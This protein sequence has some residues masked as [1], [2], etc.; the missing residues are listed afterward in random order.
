MSGY[1]D[2]LISGANTG[3]SI[4][5]GA[6]SGSPLGQARAGLTAA[7]AYGKLAGASGW[8]TGATG[9]LDAL[10]IYQGLKQ[11]GVQGYGKAAGSGLQL[12]GML[13]SNPALSAAGGYIL[14][15]LSIYNAVNNWQSGK[16]G[17]NALNGAEAGAAVGSVIPG[18]GTLIGG[19][20][21]G[22]VGA[23]SSAFGP[24]AKDPETASVQGLLD[25]TGSHGNDPR[26]AQQAS[27]PYLELAGLMDRR[28][29]TLP[30]YQQYGRM[31]EQKFSNDLAG[32][33]NSAFGDQ[34]IQSGSLKGDKWS[35]DPSTGNY[36]LTTP[37]GGKAIYKPQDA[38]AEVYN[39]TIDPWVSSMGKGYSN[40][41]D[42]Y[43]AT[44]QGLLQDMTGQYL[45]GQAAQ[46]W[47]AVGGDSPFQNIYAGSPFTAAPAAPT[48]R[49]APMA[50]GERQGA[51]MVSRGG[52]IK[53]RYDDGGDVSVDDAGAASPDWEPEL[54]D[55]SDAQ[56]QSALDQANF[57][58]DYN[59]YNI[60]NSSNDPYAYGGGGGSSNPY[61][62]LGNLLQGLGL[63]GSS[64]NSA[65]PYAALLPLLQSVLGGNKGAQAPGVPS[66]YSGP[67]LNMQSAPAFNRQQNPIRMTQDQWLHSAEGP[68]QNFYSGNQLPIT[69]MSAPN[70]AQMTPGSQGGSPY[71]GA[72]TNPYNVVGG[73]GAQV[74]QAQQAPPS[75]APGMALQVDPGSTYKAPDVSP[76]PIMWGGG[77]TGHL[78]MAAGG[79]ACFGGGGPYSIDSSGSGLGGLGHVKGPG[80]G[81]SDS[82]ALKNAYLSNGEYVIDAPTVSMAGNGS[83][84]AG[85]KV[86]DRIRSDIRKH[87]GKALARGKQPM[88]AKQ[89]NVA[90]YMG[91]GR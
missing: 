21:G 6:T 54:E 30:M 73:L 57:G 24:G 19:V 69:P 36:V 25:Y 51:K 14:A 75:N 90:N 89:V 35:V 64:L 7:K 88:T 72:Q 15:P 67:L 78:A 58:E 81:T 39:S 12:A 84:D 46:N 1:G 43:K 47:K 71:T 13:S 20:V 61:A 37:T 68:E 50:G 55:I 5:K 40:V 33:I 29:S 86:F 63:S 45:S 28:E 2:D 87:G 62:G 66:Q 65:A 79:L 74:Q 22:A 76:M 77:N 34:G 82:I 52:R 27:N 38:A 26:I 11:G 32:Q 49:T 4:Y 48:P 60:V 10:S 3:L 85:A 41:G 70:A 17:S 80:D 56:V 53:Y 91:G 18:I 42:T 31:G 83:N 16:T 44:T 9:A 8:N 23:L 59:P